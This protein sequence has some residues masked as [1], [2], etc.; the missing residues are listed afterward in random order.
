MQGNRQVI[1]CKLQKH[2]R[3]RTCAQQELQWYS[4]KQYRSKTVAGATT[5][6]EI[7]GRNPLK[8]M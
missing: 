3:A 5:T 2:I 1:N 4:D 8:N 6:P 7:E